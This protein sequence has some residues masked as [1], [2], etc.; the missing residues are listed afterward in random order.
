M[1]LGSLTDG[2]LRRG[3]INGI[4]LT[5]TVDKV[6]F[7]DLPVADDFIHRTL[8]RQFEKLKEQSN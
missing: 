8:T 4:D 1:F 5:A 7:K 3:L 6:M 2:D